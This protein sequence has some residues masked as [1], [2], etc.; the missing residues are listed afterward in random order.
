[1]ASTITYL[2]WGETSSRDPTKWRIASVAKHSKST[3]T[4]PALGWWSWFKHTEQHHFFPTCWWGYQK[5]HRLERVSHSSSV[6]SIIKFQG[7]AASFFLKRK[8]PFH[9][10]VSGKHHTCRPQQ[11]FASRGL[12]I[13]NWK[14]RAEKGFFTQQKSVGDRKRRQSGS[15]N[16]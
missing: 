16:N 10:T 9:H 13:K 12:T 8:N 5:H 4:L 2:C 15:I 7:C 6:I 11:V 1:M 3:A 14:F